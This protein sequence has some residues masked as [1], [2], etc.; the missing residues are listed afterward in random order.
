MNA[1]PVA[2]RPETRLN[3]ALEL[4]ARQRQPHLPVVDTEQRFL[5][6]VR[7]HDLRAALARGMD[8][9]NERG[10]LTLVVFAT[11]FVQ[12]TDTVEYVW[13]RISR[14]PTLNPL[15]VLSEGKLVGTVSLHDLH[16]A[17]LHRAE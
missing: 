2:A 10:V 15:P 12:A 3:D 1:N 11:P 7:E 14:A 13:G 5:G 4:M 6:I 9:A 8:D 16:S 17:G